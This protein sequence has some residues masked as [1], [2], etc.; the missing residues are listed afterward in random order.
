MAALFSMSLE[1]EYTDSYKYEKMKQLR[2]D[3][4]HYVALH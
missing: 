4:I 3:T 1:W 2:S